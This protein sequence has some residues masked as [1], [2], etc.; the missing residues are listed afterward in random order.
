[1]TDSDATLIPPAATV[2]RKSGVFGSTID[3]EI[4]LMSGEHQSYFGLDRIGSAIWQ[5]LT[6]PQQVTALCQAMADRFDGD[7]ATIETETLAFLQQLHARDLIV[8][9]R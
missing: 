9:A 3:G 7:P 6:E 8:V 5:Q 2:S 1:M 4:V